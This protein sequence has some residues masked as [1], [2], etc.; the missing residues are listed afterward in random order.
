MLCCFNMGS[1]AMSGPSHARTH[2]NTYSSNLPNCQSAHCETLKKV[3]KKGLLK[4]VAK[5][6]TQDK[7]RKGGVLWLI[8][9]GL[10]SLLIVSWALEFQLGSITGL[11]F[12]TIATAIGYLISSNLQKEK[13]NKFPKAMFIAAIVINLVAAIGL[14]ILPLIFPFD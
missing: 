12:F 4:R 6:R 13:K 1:Y 2:C 14:F 10:F 5:C 9:L 7:E 11:A 8:A 3:E